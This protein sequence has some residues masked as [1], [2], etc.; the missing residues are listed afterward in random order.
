MATWDALAL[1]A[2]TRRDDHPAMA[3]KPNVADLSTRVLMVTLG[4]ER[5]W[6]RVALLAGGGLVLLA[7]GA[8][9]VISALDTKAKAEREFAFNAL[10]TCLL[11]T[12]PLKDKETP[13]TRARAIQLHILGV[14]KQNRAAGSQ[15]PW[16]ASCATY[17]HQL[18]ESTRGSGDAKTGL[19]PSA[20]ALAKS[21]GDNASGLAEFKS[22]VDR[23]WK[24]AE[25]LGLKAGPAPAGVKPPAKV[26]RPTWT[27]EQFKELP[28]ALSGAF[29]MTNV[30]PDPVVMSR[31]GFVVDQKDVPEGPVHCSAGPA[32][33][34]LRC[35]RL[36]P[37]SLAL[38]PGLRPFGTFEDGKKPLFV[39]GDRGSTGIFSPDGEKVAS[40]ALMGA[41]LRD[42]GGAWLVARK[43]AKTTALLFAPPK[44]QAAER[45]LFG[46]GEL[47]SPAHASIAWDWLAYRTKSGKLVVRKLPT[48]AGEAGAAIEVGELTEPAPLEIAPGDD[49]VVSA[50]R[51]ADNATVFVRV[52]GGKTDAFAVFS[53]SKWSGPFKTS[54]KGGVM[55]CTPAAL[56]ITKTTNV[57]TGDKN[58]ATVT[59]TMCSRTGE[60]TQ[61]ASGV[62]EM[63]GG[64]TDLAPSDAQGFSAA[65]VLDKVAVVYHAGLIG[66]LRVRVA[67]I[68]K[69]RDAEDHAI[70]DPREEG[71]TLKLGSFLDVKVIPGGTF[72]VILV[73]TTN[74]VRALRVDGTGTLTP[75]TTSL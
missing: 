67:P 37:A 35:V 53:G 21:L 41:W 42:D 59:Q 72:A 52:R 60:C 71:G 29:S 47:E 34:G 70:F 27:S 9:V 40:V 13:A 2:T 25:K 30:R 33:T 22:D 58:L 3:K 4:S 45:P 28:R 46:P 32:D 69:L 39:A 1:T 12:E 66:G 6:K 15:L 57:I 56:T 65:S 63:T 54:S 51:A 61:G 68:G 55:T 36:P 16:P 48:A 20:D 49:D 75:L 43:D 7:G 8:Y 23:V 5:R 18:A 19:S 38:S 24:E 74:G 10:S 14:P 44:G 73:G 17:A 26:E 11:G 50:C 31:A 64:V 62:Q